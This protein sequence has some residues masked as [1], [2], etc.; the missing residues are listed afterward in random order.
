MKRAQTLNLNLEVSTFE[1]EKNKPRFDIDQKK[2][3]D[4]ANSAGG[5]PKIA[6]K[7]AGQYLL[8]S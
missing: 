4:Q 3:F 6:S 5:S 1:G 8:I 7:N 2:K